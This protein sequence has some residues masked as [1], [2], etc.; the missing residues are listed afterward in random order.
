M[1]HEGLKESLECEERRLEDE[2]HAEPVNHKVDP[3]KK[4][5]I[6]IDKFGHG[7]LD[8]LICG[9]VKF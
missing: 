4:R 5:R 7:L 8:K 6:G 9:L 3:Q 1:D 2:E